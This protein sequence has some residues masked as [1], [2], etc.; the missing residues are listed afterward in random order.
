MSTETLL[1]NSLIGVSDAKEKILN[2]VKKTASSQFEIGLVLKGLKDKI[3][4]FTGKQQEL[5]Q[6]EY[7]ALID[8]LPFG[9]TVANKFIAIASD[10][11]IK[12]YLD[13][14]PIAYNTMYAMRDLSEDQWKYFKDEG[15]NAFTTNAV[16]SELKTEYQKS[17]ADPETT[18]PES[19]EGEKSSAEADKNPATE[20]EKNTPAEDKGA[21][22]AEDSSTDEPIV[23]PTANDVTK[24]ELV[25]K[26]DDLLK[27]I[28]KLN[29]ANSNTVSVDV[30]EEVFEYDIAA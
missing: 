24:E 27:F 30:L 10:K 18:D 9:K 5:A 4:S 21:T 22:G 28:E 15:L 20:A 2:L 3:S 29:F 8:D 25:K 19:D 14:A 7:D 11:M 16:V 13:I 12:K 26:L 1:Q 6:L 23:P 17:T